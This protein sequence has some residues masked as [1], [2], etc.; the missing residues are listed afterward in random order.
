MHPGPSAE[1]EHSGFFPGNG[2]FA[3]SRLDGNPNFCLSRVADFEET[4]ELPKSK[5]GHEAGAG[6]EPANRGFADPDLTTWLP[7]RFANR[8]VGARLGGV[9]GRGP[10]RKR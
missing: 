1:D 10:S 3:L 5:S 7:R 4:E 9:N 2:T 8:S 6:I